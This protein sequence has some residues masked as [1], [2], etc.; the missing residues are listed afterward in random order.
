MT[1]EEFLKAKDTERI[2]SG[3]EVDPKKINKA[4]FPFQRDIVAWA[5]KKGKAKITVKNNGAKATVTVTV[6]KKAKKKIV[7]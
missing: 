5:L 3:F 6:K 4:L 1:Y 7:F 2:E